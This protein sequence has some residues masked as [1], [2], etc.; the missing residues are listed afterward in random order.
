MK[1]PDFPGWLRFQETEF[2]TKRAT[3][4]IQRE[5]ALWALEEAA[6]VCEAQEISAYDLYTGK[7]KPLP[8]SGLTTGHPYLEG[9]GDGALLCA[10]AIR[11]LKKNISG[12]IT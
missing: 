2:I 1:L 4:Y 3:L 10:A 9:S 11:E 7:V 12:S 5:A 8:E 6:K